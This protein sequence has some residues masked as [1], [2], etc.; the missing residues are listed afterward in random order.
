MPQAPTP[1]V[2]AGIILHNEELMPELPGLD[3]LTNWI[4]CIL[5]Q[6]SRK[7][8]G[9]YYVFLDDESLLKINR[10]HL[11]HDTYTDILTFPYHEDPVEAEIYISA[12]RIRANAKEYR[13][14]VYEELL[15]VMAHG[16]LHLCGWR[17]KTESQALLMRK[18]ENA[19]LTLMGISYSV[20]S[21]SPS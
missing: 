2:S 14:T 6:E 11:Q 7:L 18:R 4:H 9:V 19:C 8:R 16:I 21:L 5:R 17:D 1:D 10:E 15:R 13:V 12:D 20:T 3:I